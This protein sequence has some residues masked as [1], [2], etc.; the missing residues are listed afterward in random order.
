[1]ASRWCRPRCQKLQGPP[2]WLSQ[3][4][5]L[6]ALKVTLQPR[7]FGCDSSR[8]L[9]ERSV[10]RISPSTTLTTGDHAPG[11]GS[12]GRYKHHAQPAGMQHH[13]QPTGMQMPCPVCGDANAMPSL[14]GGHNC[15]CV[16]E[17]VGKCRGPGPVSLAVWPWI[18]HPASLSRYLLPCLGKGRKT[19]TLAQAERRHLIP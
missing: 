12:A 3:K 9:E 4:L 11:R 2:G 19:S 10:S 14:Q 13:A 1:M 16:S 17:C 8:S 7:E 18:Q 5:R 6:P 15:G